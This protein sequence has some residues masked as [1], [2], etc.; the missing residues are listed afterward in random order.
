VSALA[1]LGPALASAASISVEGGLIVLGKTQ[2]SPVVIRVDEPAG[3]ELYPLRLS[4]NVGR[5]SE[6]V[7]LGPGKYRAT[8]VP[9]ETR[10]PQVALVAVWRETGAD[11]RIDFLRIPL[12]GKTRLRVAARPKAEVRAHVG[13]DT[14]GPAAADRTGRAEIPIH[15]EPGVQ[16]CDVTVREAEGQEARKR[17]KVEV[18]PYNR[19]TAALVPHAV[20]ADGQSTVRLDVFYDLGGAHVT[21]DRVRV[22][23]SAGKVT[24]ERGARGLYTYRF[25][26]PPETPATTVT[27]DVSVDGDP[28]ARAAARLALGLP[29]PARVVV[30]GPPKRLRVG[31]GASGPVSVLVLDAAGMGLPGV[32]LDASAAGKP[33]GAGAYRG[34][35]LY[36][37]TLR[38]PDVYPP[39]GVVVIRARAPASGRMVEGT[40]NLQLDAPP[41]PASITSRLEPSPVPAD[42]RTEARLVLEIRDA[43]GMPLEHVQVVSV[44]SHGALGAVRERG[45]GVYEHTYLP[46]AELPDGDAQVRVTDGM[47]SFEKQVRLPLRPQARRLSLGLGAGYTRAP[48]EASGLRVVGEVWT[49]FAGR[50]GAGLS[51]GYGTA[52]KTVRDATGTLSSRTTAT[53]VPVSLKVGWDAYVGRRL[54][55]TLGGGVTGAW[56]EFKTS[57]SGEI[58][59]GFGAGW[60]GFADVGWRLGPGQVVLGLSY[61][62]VPVETADYRIDPGGLS[63]TVAYR[64]GVL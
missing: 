48:G 11:A 32:E 2:S 13:I 47:G 29:P 59:R 49:P 52:S 51:A 26:P 42:G 40:L 15:V 19:L 31:S 24:F 38:A 50:F 36:E 64:V 39:G 8:Y 20:I 6:P 57:L 23:P 10:F 34:G 7:R 5:F 56:A 46:P 41:V 45:N 28:S 61:G 16:E 25:V 33:L 37:F 43:A 4:V 63:A 62:V 27:F 12:F 17:V 58:V 14:F 35:G 55:V 22:T 44:A 53:F 3:S 54:S 1:L 30:N 21:P 18:P 9:P 60:L